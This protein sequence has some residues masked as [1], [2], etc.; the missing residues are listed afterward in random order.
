MLTPPAVRPDGREAVM[1]LRQRLDEP[2]AALAGLALG[3]SLKTF[4]GTELDDLEEAMQSVLLAGPGERSG[5]ELEASVR[6]W[7]YFAS[8]R[9]AR[10][11]LAFT[12]PVSHC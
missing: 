1:A 12:L 2:R 10:K 7:E 11:A 5:A 3:P 4:L 8:S 9:R 6:W